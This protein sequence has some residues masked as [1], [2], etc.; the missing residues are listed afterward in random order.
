MLDVMTIWDARFRKSLTVS[1]A[2]FL[3]KQ[4]MSMTAS[5]RSELTPSRI[6]RFCS[7][8]PDD[9]N[10]FGKTD[11]LV[12]AVEK[13]DFLPFGK[14]PLGDRPADDAGSSE[15]Q[16][17]HVK[18]SRIDIPFCSMLCASL[19]TTEGGLS[20]VSTPHRLGDRRDPTLPREMI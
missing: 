10:V 13:H 5:K 16:Y 9:P 7:G 12:A 18:T 20:G 19:K 15:D 4:I 6:R 1:S 17:S 11:A 8:L 14:Q 2:S 3:L